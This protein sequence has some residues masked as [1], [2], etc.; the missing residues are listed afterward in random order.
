MCIYVIPDT[1][2]QGTCIIELIVQ[3]LVILS[4]HRGTDMST[5]EYG[6]DLGN[7]LWSQGSVFCQLHVEGVCE[8]L[9]VNDDM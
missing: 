4:H 6:Y 9:G 5:L 3:S 2:Y 7:S 8:H 1:T